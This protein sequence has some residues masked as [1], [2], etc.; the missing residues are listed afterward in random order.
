MVS[1]SVERG[2]P[3]AVAERPV[4]WFFLQPYQRSRRPPRMAPTAYAKTA[5]PVGL[6]R[7]G[8]YHQTA[9]TWLPRER[10]SGPSRKPAAWSAMSERSNTPPLLSACK[11]WEKTGANG[12]IYLVG[13]A[14]GVKVPILKNHRRE[15]EADNPRHDVRGSDANGAAVGRTGCTQQRQ[16]LSGQAEAHIASAGRAPTTDARRCIA[17]LIPEFGLSKPKSM[18][19]GQATRA[20]TCRISMLCGPTP[21]GGQTHA[22]PRTHRCRMFR[23][24]F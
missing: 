14:G 15:R 17:V 8:C 10:S 19:G 12:S 24:R 3:R 18:E 2:K 5:A 21:T 7:R 6:S 22:A 16:F 13:R 23:F 20:P 4:S 1:D 9:S 11:L